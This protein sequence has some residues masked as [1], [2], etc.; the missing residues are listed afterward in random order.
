M[1]K[2]KYKRIIHNLRVWDVSDLRALGKDIEDLY[3]GETFS[4][5]TVT[6]NPLKYVGILDKS[7]NP[8]LDKNGY[9]VYRRIMEE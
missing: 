6:I 2:D 1:V 9:H 8:R 7:S 3:I 4:G 5:H